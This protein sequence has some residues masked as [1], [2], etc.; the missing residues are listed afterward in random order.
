[1][2]KIFGRENL[3]L[4]LNFFLNVIKMKIVDSN[5]CQ[6]IAS[7]ELLDDLEVDSEIIIDV[8]ANVGQFAKKIA[9]A[10]PN[11]TIFSFEPNPSLHHLFEFNLKRFKKVHLQKLGI[12]S[13][14]G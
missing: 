12:G 14:A 9:T 6:T 4:I 10:C 1:M 11:S 3:K 5:E 2:R 7:Q 13:V 8:G